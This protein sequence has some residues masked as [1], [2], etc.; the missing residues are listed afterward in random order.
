MAA[1]EVGRGLGCVLAV[2]NKDLRQ[3]GRIETGSKSGGVTRRPWLGRMLLAQKLS[4]N[5]LPSA[6]SETELEHLTL[7]AAPPERPGGT[8]KRA[9][10]W[11]FQAMRT[12]RQSVLQRAGRLTRPKGIL[13][14][15]MS[16]N[17]RVAA[18]Y[19]RLLKP[20][21]RSAA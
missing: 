16:T 21:T 12:V 3:V 2:K 6:R 7:R 9:T 1:Q 15:T 11:V 19:E 10:L 17:K 18:D 8:K 20:W 14:L 4:L 5:T 13:T